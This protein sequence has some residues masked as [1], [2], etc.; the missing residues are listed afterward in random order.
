MD[1]IELSVYAINTHS[2][3]V[4]ILFYKVLKVFSTPN[5]L[6]PLFRISRQPYAKGHEAACSIISYAQLNHNM[7]L[8]N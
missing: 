3:F 7:K 8:Q 6:S 2:T 5:R 4:F 1:L